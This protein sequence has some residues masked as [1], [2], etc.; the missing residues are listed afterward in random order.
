MSAHGCPARSLSE[1]PVLLAEHARSR[2]RGHASLVRHIS[3]RPN[4]FP[5]HDVNCRPGDP[6]GP[7]YP[8]LCFPGC[9][10]TSAAHQ[11]TS[12]VDVWWSQTGSNRRPPACKAGALPAELW[13]QPTSHATSPDKDHSLQ[14]HGGP[15]TTRTSDLT[16]IRG[17][18]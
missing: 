18:L 9:Q 4:M 3:G 8:A 17:A 13:P 15:G 6:S 2:W 10:P 5:L 14:E 11:S 1:R 12:A 16:L 7:A